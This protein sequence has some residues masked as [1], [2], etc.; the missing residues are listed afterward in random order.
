M[1]VLNHDFLVPL[2]HVKLSP[3]LPI[4]LLLSTPSVT[5]WHAKKALDSTGT[6]KVYLSSLNKYWDHSLQAKYTTIDDWVRQ[7]EQEQTSNDISVRRKWATDLENF[8]NAYISNRGRPLV[9]SAKNVVAM[10]ATSYLKHF[11]GRIRFRVTRAQNVTRRQRVHRSPLTEWL[12][13]FRTLLVSPQGRFWCAHSHLRAHLVAC[14]RSYRT[15]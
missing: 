6:A 12:T 8:V 11:L 4:T 9:E 5:R 13:R 10:A 3:R 15:T 1:S 2:G 14:S 7:T